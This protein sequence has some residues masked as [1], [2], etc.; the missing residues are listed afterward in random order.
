MKDKKSLT[1]ILAAAGIAFALKPLTPEEI[2][3]KMPK[4]IDAEYIYPTGQE[5]R[6]KRRAKER[7]NKRGR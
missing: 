7:K 6:R 1:E 2:E 3:F 4:V 5:R